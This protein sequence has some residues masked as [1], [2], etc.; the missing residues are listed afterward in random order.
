MIKFNKNTIIEFQKKIIASTGGESGVLNLGVLD[1]AIESCFATHKGQELLPT[2]EEKG[3]R[4]GINIITNHPFCDGNKRVGMLTMITFL[5][6]NGI[7]LNLSNE[8]IINYGLGIAKGEI[9]Y[10]QVLEWIQKSKQKYPT[11][12][13]QAEM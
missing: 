11:T 5:E 4:L 13:K 7:K 2:I 12:Q 6:V 1:S 3:T 10:E 8:E 9:D